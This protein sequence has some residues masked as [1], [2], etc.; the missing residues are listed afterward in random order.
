MY[1]ELI[2]NYKNQRIKSLQDNKNWCELGDEELEGMKI[3]ASKQDNKTF[4][5]IGYYYDEQ[6][7]KHFGKIP[8]NKI[9]TNVGNIVNYDNRNYRTSDPRFA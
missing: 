5:D 4:T 2:G 6:G 9:K 8:N 3:V 1:A 7:Y